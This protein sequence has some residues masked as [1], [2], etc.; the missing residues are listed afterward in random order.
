MGDWRGGLQVYG[1][2]TESLE[3]S[4]VSNRNSWSSQLSSSHLIVIHPSFSPLIFRILLGKLGV[5]G[6]AG[7]L[8]DV[9]FP[10]SVSLPVTSAVQAVV[11]HGP[12]AS[13]GPHGLPN[14]PLGDEGPPE[15]HGRSQGPLD[16]ITRSLIVEDWLQR[17]RGHL[18]TEERTSV[19]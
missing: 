7:R 5:S 6:H 13:H 9:I 17:Y 16:S 2:L 18:R 11:R 15:T 10:S 3:H 8:R 14:H 1:I 12:D 19:D 4:K